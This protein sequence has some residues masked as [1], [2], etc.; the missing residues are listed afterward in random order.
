M[1]QLYDIGNLYFNKLKMGAG[2]CKNC[3]GHSG[4]S[5]RTSLPNIKFTKSVEEEKLQ[6]NDIPTKISVHYENSP[7]P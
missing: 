4:V 6:N 5:P 3:C 2:N 1:K 7:N